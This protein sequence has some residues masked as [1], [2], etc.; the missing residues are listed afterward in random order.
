MLA[1][2]KKNPQEQKKPDSR[3]SQSWDWE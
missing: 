2:D 1:T 3:Q